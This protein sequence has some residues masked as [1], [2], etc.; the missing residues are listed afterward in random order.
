MAYLT[1]SELEQKGFKSLGTNVLISEKASIYNPRNISIG[2]NVRIDDFCIISAGNKGVL[3]GNHVHIACYV[4]IIGNELISLGDFVGISAR[5]SIYS[6][7][8]DYGGNFLFGPTIPDKFKNIT[9]KSV[10]IK[11]YVIIGVNCTILPGVIIN[12]GVAVGAYT[13]INKNLNEWSIYV[14]IPA[15][16]IKPR[17]KGVLNIDVNKI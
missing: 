9:H 15:K 11:N 5:S 14:G 13:L 17:L 10:E 7:N 6:S 16:K 3:I 4:S 2:S 8:D 1:R 12:T